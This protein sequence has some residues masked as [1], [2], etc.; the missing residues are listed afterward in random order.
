LIAADLQSIAYYRYKTYLVKTPF[1]II[2]CALCLALALFGC[3]DDSATSSQTQESSPATTTDAGGS[4]D[5]EGS[6]DDGESA[7]DEQSAD[8]EEGGGGEGNA[9]SQSSE[10]L[11][12]PASEVV[13]GDYEQ[14]G[15]FSAITGGTGNE[16]PRF[17]PSGEPAPKEVVTREL[18]VGS[19]PA[20]QLGDQAYVYYAGAEYDTGKVTVYGWLGGK[21]AEVVIGEGLF[22]K[23]WE[24][25]I[26]GMKVGGIRQVIIPESEWA[27]GKPVDYVVVLKALQPKSG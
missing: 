10:R 19:G 22:G 11:E 23:T 5:G 24:K 25:T 27:Q 4:A 21:P 17:T 12:A 15:P 2:A 7:D 18:Q 3:G 13:V 26:V 14:E 1:L 8:G 16:K 20:A 6:A 9:E